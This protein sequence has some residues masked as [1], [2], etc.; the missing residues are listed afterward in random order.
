MRLALVVLM[1]LTVVLAGCVEPPSETVEE[2][3]E[4]VLPTAAL[5]PAWD[6]VDHTAYRQAD[7]EDESLEPARVG[8]R[9]EK[10]GCP[11]FA[12]QVNEGRHH[13]GEAGREP[14]TTGD[15]EALLP[16]QRKASTVSWM[17]VS[18]SS[19]SIPKTFS[20]LAL[21]YRVSPPI[22]FLATARVR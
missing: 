9:D 7:G 1:S 17:H 22:M 18:K 15:Q 14:S 13:N 16:G 20:A 12:Q 6:G 10:R 4:V 19:H 8:F 3:M 2:S 5:F 11:R 21:E